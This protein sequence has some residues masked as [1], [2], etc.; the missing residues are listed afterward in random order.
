MYVYR[1]KTYKHQQY[2]QTYQLLGLTRNGWFHKY[3]QNQ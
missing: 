3:E 1:K 2:H